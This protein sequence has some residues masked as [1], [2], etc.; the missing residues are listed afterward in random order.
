MVL[1]E[2]GFSRGEQYNQ[3]RRRGVVCGEITIWEASFRLLVYELLGCN[4]RY[5]RL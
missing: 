4:T 2:D 1:M 3:Q 5:K